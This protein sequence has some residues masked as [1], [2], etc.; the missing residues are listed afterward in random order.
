[1]G[2]T[3]GIAA[4]PT[5]RN[6]GDHS[7]AL[8]LDFDPAVIS[9]REVLAEV[10]ASHHPLKNFGGRQY[11]HA[12]WYHNEDQ[13]SVAEATR[14]EIAGQRGVA[15]E[16]I[17]TAL[18]PIGTFTYAEDYH[19]KYMLRRQ[20]DII[21]ELESLF[22]D[23]LAFTDSAAMTRLNGWFGHGRKSEAAAFCNE[24]VSFGLPERIES[25]LIARI[26]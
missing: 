17:R 11:R 7:E 12:I 19:Q 6:I 5:Y 15:V 16:K 21:T 25:K 20:G 13:K 1:M 4:N 10:W 3:G 23:H 26:S 8:A 14:E 24:I 18:E 2:Y 22:P 9:Y